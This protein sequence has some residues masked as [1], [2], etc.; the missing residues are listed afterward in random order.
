MIGPTRGDRGSVVAEFA[1]ALPAVVL[2]LL[3]PSLVPQAARWVRTFPAPGAGGPSSDPVW[4]TV[5]AVAVLA[6]AIS[7]GG[8]HMVM[9][10]EGHTA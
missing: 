4:W 10:G 7:T 2:V 8:G 5:L 1:V 6:I 3:A 9:R